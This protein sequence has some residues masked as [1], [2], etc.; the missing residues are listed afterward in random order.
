[1]NRRDVLRMGGLAAAALGVPATSLEAQ[2]RPDGA[3]PPSIASL[4]S[5]RGQARP[6]S[7]DERLARLEKARRLMA[8]SKI[9]AVLL[10]GGTTLN[11]FT[12]LRWGNSER[13]MA[14]VV[15][16]KGDP[17]VV[18]PAFEVDRLNEQLRQSPLRRVDVRSWHENESP[19]QRVADTLR[20]RGIATGRLGI[21]ETV[22]FVF[23]N[24]VASALPSMTVTSATP[25]TAGCRMIKDAHELELLRLACRATLTCYAAVFAA[26]TPGM[27]ETAATS[28]VSAG[29]ARL[30]F[31]GSAS[32]QV[33]PYTALPHGSEEPQTIRE[34]SIVMIDDGCVVEG[35]QADLTRTFVLGT[36]TDKMKRVFDIVS[37]A[38]R[39]ALAAARPGATLGSVDAAARKVIVDAGFGPGFS[40]F[41]HRLGHGLGMDMHEWPY[42]VEHNMY[43]WESPVLQPGMVFSN[44]P[45]IY[46]PG[47]FG[48]RLED[49]MVITENGAEL[50]TPPSRSIERP[51][52]A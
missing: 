31:R 14:L 45:G 39:A 10:T 40:F 5:M 41:T 25:V 17:F 1:M 3:L 33:G 46:I 13:L 47:E 26:L 43:G 35:Y 28:L 42:L 52:D 19:Y 32:V 49:D 30:G 50:L 22:R 7:H 4:S 36:A 37:A 24:G 9:D 44:E 2:T 15:P 11:Y 6:I 27:T 23:A 48:I 8:A 20:E 16:A 12:G 29:Y 34:H 18:C 38:Q 51:F 21:E